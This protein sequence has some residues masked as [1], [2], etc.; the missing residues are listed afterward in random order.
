MAI[1]IDGVYVMLYL[2]SL[3]DKRGGGGRL[4]VI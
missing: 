3:A 4:K 2:K 1:N